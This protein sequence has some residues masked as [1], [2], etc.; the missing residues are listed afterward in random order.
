MTEL[1]CREYIQ[2]L[3]REAVRAL[4][5]HVRT[6]HRGKAGRFGRLRAV[7]GALRSMNPDAVAGL[8]FRPVTGTSSMDEHVLAMFYER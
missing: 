6:T 2:A 4:Y 3:Q 5:D 1:E 7:L 8:F